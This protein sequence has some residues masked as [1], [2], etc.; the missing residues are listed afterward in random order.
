MPAIGADEGLYAGTSGPPPSKFD[1]AVRVRFY[2]DAIPDKAASAAEGRPVYRDVEFV[3]KQVVGD[4]TSTIQRP[5][6]KQD[7][8]AHPREYAL[9]RQ[10]DTEQLT[11]T[12]LREW[13]V[14]SKSQVEEL[15]F[16]KVRTVE[17]LASISDGNLMQIGP[18]RALRDRA[19]DWLE[20]A[21]GH[22]PTVA[23]RAELDEKEKRIKGLESELAE[24]KA[25]LM[26]QP[27]NS[28]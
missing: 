22:A 18:I 15:A 14:A 5:S 23:L 27:K 3:E 16:F 24:V 1:G 12:P 19:K 20:T 6:T 28:K 4:K 9:F 21:K 10:G 17:Q 7:Q 26:K 13:P 25:L 2:V 8:I 11:G